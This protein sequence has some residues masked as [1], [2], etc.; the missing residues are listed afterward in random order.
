MASAHKAK[1]SDAVL[2]RP[3][4]LYLPMNP[5]TLNRYVVSRQI[6]LCVNGPRPACVERE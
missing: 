6:D 2:R 1:A 5:T 3:V 4:A